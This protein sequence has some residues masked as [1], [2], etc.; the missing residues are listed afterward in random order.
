MHLQTKVQSTQKKR[1]LTKKTQQ[2]ECSLLTNEVIQ[3]TKMATIEICLYLWR[4]KGR[5]VSTKK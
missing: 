3:N 5:W 1:I 2:L 4:A